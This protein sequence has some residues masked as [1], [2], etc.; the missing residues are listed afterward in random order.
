MSDQSN[1]EP[2]EDI[3][4]PLRTG[5]YGP[6]DQAKIIEDMH[7]TF[8]TDE[9]LPVCPKC[10]SRDDVIPS[11]MGLPTWEMGVYARAGHAE[12]LGC[13]PEP[14]KPMKKG[15]CKKCGTDIFSETTW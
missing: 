14:G 6:N 3:R 4:G 9:R 7:K 11:V 13:C 8:R 10:K 5:K 15:K 1:E 12:L 2:Q